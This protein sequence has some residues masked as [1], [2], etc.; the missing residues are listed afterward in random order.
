MSRAIHWF[1]RDLRLEDNAAL[2]HALKS[3]KQV[4]CIFIFDRQILDRLDD[5]KDARVTFIHQE[6]TR[7]NKE[8]QDLGSSLK[9]YY[10]NPIDLWPEIARE[11]KPEAVFALKET[12]PLLVQ[13]IYVAGYPFDENLSPSVKITKSI[14]GLNR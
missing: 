7:L 6:L 12:N 2:Y 8:L 13:E 4:Q 1:R 5:N 10:G 14:V 9:T 11:L 3:G